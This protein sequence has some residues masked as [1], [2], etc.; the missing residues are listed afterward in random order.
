MIG[1]LE[2]IPANYYTALLTQQ[3]KGRIPCVFLFTE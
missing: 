1:G 2:K 3:Y